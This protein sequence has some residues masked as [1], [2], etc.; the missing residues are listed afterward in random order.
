MQIVTSYSLIVRVQIHCPRGD[1]CKAT[2]I[3]FL[4]TP[5]CP[6][7]VHLRTIGG[8]SVADP[9]PGSGAFLGPVSGMGKKSGDPDPGSGSGS[10]PG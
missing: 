5:P 9:D 8:G 6:A 1:F 3:Y 7:V 10:D 2:L 4:I